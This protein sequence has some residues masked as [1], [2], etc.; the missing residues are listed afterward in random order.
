MKLLTL[1]QEVTEAA[2]LCE[3]QAETNRRQMEAA[4]KQA[5][6]LQAVVSHFEKRGA[7][8]RALLEKLD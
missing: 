7:E 2:E 5:D 6:D 8:Y 1:K 4:R 3:Q